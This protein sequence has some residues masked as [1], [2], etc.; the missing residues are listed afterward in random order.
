V[1]V[2]RVLFGPWIKDGGW[3]HAS[4]LMIDAGHRRSLAM[5]PPC[6]LLTNPD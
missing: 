2:A 3:R 6:A 5:V 1:L 4:F